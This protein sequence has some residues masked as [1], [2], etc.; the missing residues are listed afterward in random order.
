MRMI[1]FTV[2]QKGLFLCFQ[3]VVSGPDQGKYLM[4]PNAA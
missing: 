4:A 1:N 2:S 3:D